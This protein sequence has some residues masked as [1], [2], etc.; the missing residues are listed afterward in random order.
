MRY[1]W[2]LTRFIDDLQDAFEQ[3]EDAD[4]TPEFIEDEAGIFIFEG[5]SWRQGGTLG[6]QCRKNHSR[7]WADTLLAPDEVLDFFGVNILDQV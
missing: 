6:W 3:E 5:K 2:S 7:D 1:K 4:E